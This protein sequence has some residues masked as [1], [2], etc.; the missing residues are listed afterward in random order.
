LSEWGFFNPAVYREE[1]CWKYDKVKREGRRKSEGP[2][3][4]AVR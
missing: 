3:M 2:S 4:M 1:K